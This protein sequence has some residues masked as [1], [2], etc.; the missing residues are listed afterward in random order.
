MV[1]VSRPSGAGGIAAERAAEA[2]AVVLRRF[3]GRFLHLPATRMARTTTAIHGANGT[4]HVNGST[5]FH[6]WW[7]AH[8][9]DAIV[10]GGLRR[11]RA[12]DIAAARVSAL[13]GRRLLGTIFLRNGATWRNHF[14]DD[15][16]WLALAAQRLG[17]LHEQLGRREGSRI[18]G[19]AQQALTRELLEGHDAGG[20]VFWNKD[21]SFLNAAASGPAAL[22]LVRSG[23]R[24][25]ARAILEWIHQHLVDD[26]GLIVDGLFVNGRIERRVY[27]YNQGPA[28]AALLALGEPEDLERASALVEA[29]G[30]HLSDPGSRVLVTHGTGDGGL[31]TGI[32]IRYLVV[33][34]GDERLDRTCRTMADTLVRATATALWAGRDPSG[35]FPSTL[36]RTGSSATHIACVE[37]S[38]QLQGW[39][40][41]EALA[42]LDP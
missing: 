4:V 19:W 31:F 30:T 29:V 9:L 24:A 25:E 14:F 20:G 11:L 3:V 6:Y 33:A 15:M 36:D 41:M 27:T 12:H 40:A 26:R 38:T 16:A 7:Q 5:P 18:R 39:I 2:E 42:L 37:L 21:R 8:L 34:A 10:D 32:L 28:L 22:H 35:V 13:L 23:Q 17:E 1:L